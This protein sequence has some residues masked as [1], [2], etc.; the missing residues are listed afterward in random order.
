MSY[1]TALFLF[2]VF[3]IPSAILLV[4]RVIYVRRRTREEQSDLEMIFSSYKKDSP[5]IFF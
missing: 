4:A 1:D 2:F 5:Q 3:F